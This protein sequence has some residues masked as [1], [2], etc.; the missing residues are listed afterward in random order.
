VIPSSVGISIS[1][2]AWTFKRYIELIFRKTSSASGLKRSNGT[3][4]EQSPAGSRVW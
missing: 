1:A 2:W 4:N 3:S